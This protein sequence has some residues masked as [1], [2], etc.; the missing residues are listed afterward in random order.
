MNTNRKTAIGVGILF[1]IG[2]VSG[3]ISGVLTGPVFADPEYLVKFSTNANLIITGALFVLMMGFSL[4][5]V[6]LLLFPILKKRNEVLALGYVVFRGALE[7]VTY[8][9]MA[10]DWLFLL[11]LSREF[12]KTEAAAASNFLPLGAMLLKG[13]DT[14]STLLIFVFGLGALMLYYLFYRSR[15]IPRWLSSWGLIAIFLHLTTGFL[16][17]FGAAGSDSAVINMMNLPIFLQELV[18]AVWLIVKGFN[19]AAIASD[20]SRKK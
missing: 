14:V 6:P 2:T 5:V 16:L 19:P 15:L 17:I 20:P 9:F 8:I 18:M 4:A 13:S 1:I 11:N 7:T 12:T 3:V 10:V